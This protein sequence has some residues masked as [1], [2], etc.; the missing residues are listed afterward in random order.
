[1]FTFI[2]LVYRSILVWL[3]LIS[4]NFYTQYYKYI[5]SVSKRESNAVPIKVFFSLAPRRREMRESRE[6]WVS[7]DRKGLSFLL[8][9][10]RAEGWVSVAL[11]ARRTNEDASWYFRTNEGTFH[12]VSNRYFVYKNSKLWPKMDSMT[13]DGLINLK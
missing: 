8:P 5:S 4:N 9:R 2:L 11:L 10:G 12:T 1:M 7:I 6:D 13:I 3:L